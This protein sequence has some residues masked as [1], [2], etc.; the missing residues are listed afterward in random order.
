MMIKS[1]RSSIKVAVTVLSVM[2]LIAT[3]IAG[4]RRSVE[5]A[6]ITTADLQSKV[7]PYDT[8]IK[9][10]GKDQK[11][12]VGGLE[13]ISSLAK[14]IESEVDCSL[15]VST[16]DDL[17][18]A[19]Y[20]K[21]KG[22][23][24]IKAM[25]MA[26]YDVVTPG[27]HEFDLGVDLY[28]NAIK[29]A[30]FDI[31]SSNL[32]IRNKALSQLIK[33][34]ITKEIKGLKIGVFGLMTPELSEV[35]SVEEEISVDKDV[36]KIAKEMVNTL[37][38]KG[39]TMIV[40]LT[41]IGTPLDRELAK[42]V[43]GIHVIVG[44]HS[45]EYVYEIVE[46]PNKWKT[47]IIQD[48][49][50]GEKMGVLRFN[51][52]GVVNNPRWQTVVLDKSVGKDEK[53]DKF[54]AVYIDEYNK[55]LEKPVGVSLTDLDARKD[56]VRRKESILGNLITDSWIHWFKTKGKHI[57]VALINGGALRGDRVYS[58][59]PV[60]LKDLREI[61]PFGDMVMEATLTGAE[62]LQVL[63]ISASSIRVKG[64]EC[65]GD[66]RAQE[67]GF[68]QLSRVRLDIDTTNKPF[69]AVYDGRDVKRILS[70]G[71][72]IV[73]AEILENGVWKPIDRNKEY[74]VLINSWLANGG[75]GYYIFRGI[76]NKK[77]TTFSVADLLFLYIKNNSPIDPKLEGRINIK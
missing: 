67:G 20:D 14:K 74:T 32:I 3:V 55:N 27:N 60:T 1:S 7:V 26:G 77:D 18:G 37:K 4:C 56:T 40:A 36:V 21:F 59:G 51:F 28:V 33:P 25:N 69:C 22:I 6:I 13:R 54:L 66:N 31:V 75:D 70:K 45:H 8:K 76:E 62:L 57:D 58:A 23:P 68:L 24:E 10:D 41:H 34:Y 71:E 42:K 39:A 16:G 63:E 72:R 2:L 29:N 17:M 11:I 49:A 5:V 19:F 50:C 35:S 65:S 53:I 61:Y 48:G 15:F 47:V 73:K 44:G 9:V 46:G 43:E 12:A 30:R 38:Q 52:N 64:D